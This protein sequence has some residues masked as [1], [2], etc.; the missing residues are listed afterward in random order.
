M[1]IKRDKP[2]NPSE[3]RRRVYGVVRDEYGQ[4]L[5]GVTVE[6]F[7]RDLRKLQPLGDKDVTTKGRYEIPYTRA[8]FHKAEKD[9]ADLVIRITSKDGEQLHETS[10][11]FNAPEE[12]E[13]NI[14]LKDAVY[15]GSSEW[16]K[17]DGTLQSLLN[18][19]DPS[20]LLEGAPPN[21]DFSFLVGETGNSLATIVTWVVCL[22]LVKMASMPS[23][24]FFAF[25]RQGQP[26]ILTSTFEQDIRDP[27]RMTLLQ[28][29][30]LHGI[31]GMSRETQ[32]SLLKKAIAANIIPARV[33]QFIPDILKNL[34]IIHLG[35]LA[36]NNLG[37]GKG[38]LGE[39][40]V[41]VLPGEV[42]RQFDFIEAWSAHTGP[43]NG[44]WKKL[45]GKLSDDT[46]EQVK[47][48]IELGALT[49]NHIPLVAVLME[50]FKK[51]ELT[52]KRDLAK[53]SRDDWKKFFKLSDSN[54]NPINVPVTIDGDSPDAKMDAFA[55]KLEQQFE[56]AYP[57]T[58]FAA[59]LDRATKSP[60]KA[61]NEITLFLENNPDFHL[62]R[63]RV[64]Q[65]I[66]ERNKVKAKEED[67]VLRGIQEKDRPALIASLKSV[68][69]IFKLDPTY[70]AV[71]A[72]LTHKIDSA[73][74]IYFMGRQQFISAVTDAGIDKLRAKKLYNKAHNTYALALAWFGNY[75]IAMNGLIP[76]G[77]RPPIPD[78]ETLQA[79]D[80][81]PNLKSLF[82]SLDYC[83]CSHCRSVYS[84]AAY[85]VDVMRFLGQFT[86]ESD[87]NKTVRDVLLNRRPD[88]A[89]IELSCENTNVPLPYIDLVNE[90][91]EDA[92]AHPAI[93]LDRVSSDDLPAG[94]ITQSLRDKLT[95]NTVS[96]QISSTA[97]VFAPDSRNHW[98]VRDA[99]HAYKIYEKDG[100]LLLIPFRQTFL[101][102]AEL[103]AMPEYTNQNAYTEL[104][105]AVFP[106]SMPF[107][108]WQVQAHAYLN[109]LGLPLARLL[110][111]F[112]QK[113]ADGT[114]LP[115]EVQIDCAW[116]G[117]TDVERQIL[118]GT[119]PR[120]SWEFWG[121]KENGN[122]FPDPDDPI[123]PVITGHWI[124][125]LKKVH[126][127]LHHSGLEYKELLQL[128]DM[129]YVK[130][131][132]NLE[133]KE[134][135]DC[136]IS[137]FTISVNQGA[138]DRIHRFIRLW[139][140]LGCTMWELD[141]ML[142][143]VINDAI[144][145]KISGI[146]RLCEQ[147]NLDWRTVYS[148][149]NNIDHERYLDH[150]QEGTPPVQ[151]LYQRLFCNK[152]VDAAGSF[153]PE[154]NQPM[155]KIK[156]KVPAILAAFRIDEADLTLILTDIGSSNLDAALDINILSKIHRVTVLARALNLGIEPFLQ[157]KH[158]WNQDP[159]ANPQATR[160]FVKLA[161]QIAASNFSVL[162]LDYLLTYS[163]M[164][165]SG[166]GLDDKTIVGFLQ[167]LR[168]G[169]QKISDDLRLK[170]AETASNY[171]K[172]KLGLLPGLEK[173]TDQATALLIIND[174]WQGTTDKRNAFFDRSFAAWTNIAE[175][176]T[177]L[178]AI[179]TGLPIEERFKY[180]QSALQSFLLKTQNEAI[181]CQ[182]VADLL[183]LDAT[184]TGALLRGLNLS[185][186]GIATAL[187]QNINHADLLTQDGS[188]N[189]QFGLDDAR[190]LSTFQSLRLLYKV[191]LMV[192]KL[193][194]KPSELAWW[195][196]GSHAADMGW[197]HPQNFPI[198]PT[199]PQLTIEKWVAIWQFFTWKVEFPSS[200]LTAFDFAT[201]PTVANL[202]QLTAWKV[203]DINT[204]VK[205]FHGVDPTVIK[206]ELRKPANLVHLADCMQALHRLGI[207]AA[208]ALEWAK[209][210]PTDT[211]A[212]S[213]KQTVKARYDLVQWLQVIEPIQ[214]TFREQKRQA[215]VDWLTTHPTPNRRCSTADE[216]YNHFLIDVEMSACMPSSRLK[217]A[218]ASAQ[219]FVQRCLLN[220]EADIVARTDPADQKANSKWKQWKWMKQYRLWEA[221]R[222]VFLYPE[223]WLEPEL[224]DE[225]SPF[226]K[227]LEAELMQNDVT[228]ETAEDAYLNYLEKLEK[229]ANLEI[230]VMH[231]EM[232]GEDKQVL[233]VFGRTRSS[234]SPEYYYR[235]QIDG[236][237]WTVWEKVELEI[238][239]NHLMA[240]VY[241]RRLYLFWPQFIEKAS[242]QPSGPS[243]PNE[244]PKKYWEIRL[245]WSELKKGKWMPKV[246]SDSLIRVNQSKTDGDKPQNITFR[247]RLVPD[248]QVRLYTSKHPKRDAPTSTQLFDKVGKQITRQDLSDY[249]HLISPPESRY[250]NNLISHKSGSQYFYY[251]S[252]D[253]PSSMTAITAHENAA[254]IKLLRKITKGTYSVIDS[255]GGAFLNQGSFFTWDTHHTYFVDYIWQPGY[256]HSS[257][258]W[259]ISSI[260]SFRFFIHYHP[261]VEL[262]IKELN[263]GGIKGLLNR[264]IQ[265]EP[266]KVLGHPSLFDFSDYDPVPANV[267]KNY[268]LPD[269]SYSYPIEDVDFTYAGAYS[270]YNWELFF[271]VPFFIANKLSANQRFEESLEWL[272]YIFNPT[273]P[274]N[275][276]A[277]P[278]TP[279]QKFWITKPFYQ[280]TK[281]DYYRQNIV[282]MM[283]A[284]AQGEDKELINQVDE[285]R[286]NPFKPHLIARMRTVAYQKNVLI[287]YIQTLIAWGDQL[288]RRDTIESMNE[289]TQLYVLASSILGRRP[290]SIPQRGDDPAKTFYQL[291]QEDT[292]AFGNALKGVENLLPSVS[293]LG[294]PDDDAPELPSLDTLYFCIP[295]NEKL[296]ALWDTVADRLFKLRHCMNIEGVV[297]IP[298]LFEPPIDPA[299]LVKAAA[300]GLDIGAVLGD[301]NAPLPL[302]RFNFMIQRALEIC[303]EVKSLGSAMLSALEKRD[304][305]AFTR[306]RAS[307]ERMMLDRVR[308]IKNSQVD[309]AIR[310]K[311]ALEASKKMIEVRR[312][313]YQ[314]LINNGWNNWE[315]AWLALTIGAL[316]LD[317]RGVGLEALGSSL[318]LFAQLEG[319]TAGTSSPVVTF[320]FGGTNMYM[321]VSGAANALKGLSSIAQMG[322]GMTSTIGSYARRDEDWALQKGLAEKE[323]PQI[324]KQIA[325]A[326]IRYQIA[327][328]DLAN[329]EKQIENAQKEDDYMRTKFTNQELYDWMISQIST[330]YFQSYQLAYDIAKRA[331]RCFRY[332]LGVGDTSYIQF[333]Y[334]D[335]LKKGLL[336]GEKL[337]YDLKRLETAYY[338]QNRREYELTKH[339]SLAQ[340]DPVALLQLRQ[341]GECFVD[342]PETVFDMD[343][344]G[345]YFRRIKTVGLSIPCVAGPNTTIACT[346]TLTSNHLRKDSTLVANKYVRDITKDDLRFRDEIAAVQ[347]IATSNAQNDH[348]M[349]ELN[350]H[351]ER[352]LPFEGA[353]A[354]S[355]WHIKLNKDFPQ[356]NFSS[357]PDVVIHL[358]YTAREGGEPLRVKV[359]EEFNKK[360]NE[361]ALAENR[362]GLFRV[363]D[364]KREYSAKWNKFLHPANAADDQELILDDLP[365]RLPYFASRFTKKIRQIDVVAQMKDGDS[366]KVQLSPLP[367]LLELKL[368]GTPYQGLHWVRESRAGNEIAF[369]TFTIK[370]QRN[371]AIDFKSLPADAIQEL[372]IIV[373][374]TLA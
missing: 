149:Y 278:D 41:L 239:A 339:I 93:H 308:A 32:E 271:H 372:F 280:T 140:K 297:R 225:K 61:K 279:Q 243:S 110:E 205:A 43:L 222:K 44:F 295:H 99:Q 274:D 191:A 70:Q 194:M 26:S 49:S 298:A 122:D 161:D 226:F 337:F 104:K 229:V 118:T 143:D 130:H 341:N 234:R 356:F 326:E 323:L 324:N 198:D 230:R 253:G 92:V 18:G 148:F 192:S 177:K 195:L 1:A 91:L 16:E 6:A 86:T 313:H 220:L 263:R 22:R 56:R 307:H 66:A 266:D 19:V 170:D 10:V 117:I 159:F 188:S 4:P 9:S 123:A 85:F 42:D 72:L 199:L 350:F 232:N 364:L 273:N 137:K 362:S 69:R 352:Y 155:D 114:F 303:N 13:V 342:I 290:R 340:L 327:L 282:N 182:K 284:I 255:Q 223:N 251:S 241:N 242:P 156:D 212:E 358:N 11:L 133:I 96:I 82:G 260:A 151:T 87:A 351:D 365:E 129:R 125:A 334:W 197:M 90:V 165:K 235:K 78:T 80:A 348:G 50:K 281:A 261:F 166:M 131:T 344:P 55:A 316:D 144:L 169:L 221:N 209:S 247:T 216:L 157:L 333:G 265:V 112:K 237:R 153:P 67:D 276:I 250:T 336:S 331:E 215:L 213:M 38:T 108:L 37:G 74:Q 145:Q 314:K 210:E 62:D 294:T 287:K 224:R 293:S 291:Q 207:N 176:K 57:T 134:A 321:S 167:A 97:K 30:L 231:N 257:A 17:L 25:I 236:E 171:I 120:D 299:L 245:F 94:T 289:A 124:S 346:L 113:Q 347:S 119:F 338:E 12:A 73:Q 162:E 107:D 48:V 75:N 52:S 312:D 360:M 103:R 183:Q 164:P 65:Y 204:L 219:L 187:L 36:K 201:D 311:E 3:P 102:A 283:L 359:V 152:L 202:T 172:S 31:A 368:S 88:L 373:N 132:D 228:N 34:H 238:N 46:I 180:V 361:L 64:E 193:Q 29:K 196:E 345:H 53:Y 127:L 227:E 233:H 76:F 262:F 138:L 249:E 309:E 14:I 174:T 246:L 116:S 58:S 367:N 200:G 211:T 317:L 21:D 111:L 23:E 288:F 181:I 218:A 320:K 158:L 286:E 189:Y 24:V 147:F 8:D 35:Q 185:V 109:H 366:Y 2:A 329:H 27:Q 40:L 60:V 248:F 256:S 264:R 154:P 160:K 95:A 240:G 332:E 258:S 254:T 252:F 310:A 115:N 184:S 100:S 267:I 121:L 208:R 315:K 59:K 168:E 150:S 84:P 178:A 51:G 139:R 244:Q 81:Q 203:D 328:Q 269:K 353:G 39:L 7:D 173:D 142:P 28:D 363:F 259:W 275:T 217:Q 335:S 63:Y 355:S 5:D 330:V 77:I 301:I 83:E 277:S 206:Q 179:P 318:A 54:E 268:Q 369:G 79:I 292:D 45:E 98:A 305:E 135:A 163:P 285:W 128:C 214:D 370:L 300:A 106:L 175:T 33:R 105:R 136:D 89:E 343:Y 349:F 325:A 319:G 68:Q 71:E 270:L 371:G 15:N 296:L 304:A 190:F 126:I 20:E 374:Y 302:Y 186:A 354:I 47:H 272:H 146:K 357:I 141:I 306:L 322:A 101:S